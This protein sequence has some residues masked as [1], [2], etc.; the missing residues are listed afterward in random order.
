MT[1]HQRIEMCIHLRYYD[2]Y[3][4]RYNIVGIIDKNHVGQD[5]GLAFSKQSKNIPIFSSVSQAIMQ[6]ESKPHYGVI[7]VAPVGGKLSDSLTQTLIEAISKGIHI[8]S[9]LHC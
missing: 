2:R 7:G 3:I 5:A 1:Y 9:G 8:V 4:D 6:L